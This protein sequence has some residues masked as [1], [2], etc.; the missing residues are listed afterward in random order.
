VDAIVLA[1]QRGRTVGWAQALRQEWRHRWWWVLLTRK[2]LGL[3]AASIIVL[4]IVVALIGPFIAPYAY[5]QFHPET[6][7]PPSTRYWFGTDRFGRDMF[8][9]VL[10]G[11]R[12]AMLIGLMAMGFGTTLGALLGALSGYVGGTFD[13]VVQRLMDVLLAFP[14]I[15]LAMGMLALLPPSIV[16]ISAALAILL[17]PRTSKVIRTVALSVRE[18]LYVEAA[19][20]SGASSSA[21][22]ARHIIP[23]CVGPY[24]VL[25]S[26]AVGTAILVEGSLSFLGIGTP[27]DQPTWGA[28]L[29]GSRPFVEVAPWLV[30]FPGLALSV[31][32]FAFNV[33]GDALRDVLDPRLR[34]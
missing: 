32:V 34:T 15:V 18:N 27:V 6:L 33:F 11:T 25:A 9:R 21:I 24:L 14:L 12:V 13:F 2:P 10:Q 31:A 20:A 1:D 17:I 30:I 26:G 3:I 7:R 28:L 16:N 29:Q 22:V 19:R 4:L 5:D 8:S 23:N